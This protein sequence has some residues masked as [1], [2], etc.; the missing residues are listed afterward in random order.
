MSEKKPTNSLFQNAARAALEASRQVSASIVKGIQ[1]PFVDYQ[2]LSDRSIHVGPWEVKR[3]THNK[4]HGEF[5]VWSFDRQNF[6]RNFRLDQHK[7]DKL[8]RLCQKDAR[9]STLLRHPYILQIVEPI[10]ETR[11]R[12]SFVSEG[13]KMPLSAI[14]C[15][16][17]GTIEVAPGSEAFHETLTSKILSELEIKF[18]LV[19]ICEA[20]R[21]IHE[22]AHLMHLS[23]SPQSVVICSDHSF[24]ICGFQHSCSLENGH[25]PDFN[26]KDTY[27]N[28]PLTIDHPVLEWTA[29]ELVDVWSTSCSKECDYFSFGLLARWLLIGEK[30]IPDGCSL[31][32]YNRLLSNWK[33]DTTEDIRISNVFAILNREISKRAVD[34]PSVTEL[35]ECFSEDKS[36]QALLFLKSTADKT[37]EQKHRFIVT[38]IHEELLRSLGENLIAAVLIP[39]ILE[40]IK[41]ET[42]QEVSVRVL[43]NVSD[44]VDASI[45]QDIIMPVIYQLLKGKNK[46]NIEEI[47]K[48]VQKFAKLSGP[49]GEE[50]TLAILQASLQKLC[51][52]KQKGILETVGKIAVD[53]PPDIQQKFCMIYLQA[54]AKTESGQVRLICLQNLHQCSNSLALSMLDTVFE[55]MHQISQVDQS[56]PTSAAISQLVNAICVRCG[57]KFASIRALPMLAPMLCRQ[58]LTGSNFQVVFSAIQNI[59]Q[60]IRECKMKSSA[61]KRDTAITQGD[62]NI[63]IGNGRALE[64]RQGTIWQNPT[65]TSREMPVKSGIVEDDPFESLL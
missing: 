37:L 2:I 14:R 34:R 65:P 52:S 61:S 11:N 53:Y 56:G 46:S 19:C 49:A 12:I 50:I 31:N 55:K 59:L 26:F 3:A 39:F 23:I 57:P 18:G 21:F 41:V 51:P 7:V 48:N 30:V 10:H 6:A 47:A 36:I 44:R 40:S 1:G 28:L 45:F 15:D 25:K 9:Q 35:L 33:I 43:V 64:G 29:P 27:D 32:T 54:C 13:V 22:Q 38:S 24:K 8:F 20:I 63:S 42:L 5:C 62:P 16:L 4:K 58:S 17:A 60:G